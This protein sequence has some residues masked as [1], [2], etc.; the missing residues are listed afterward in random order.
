[1]H[2]THKTILAQFALELATVAD[3]SQEEKSIV[4]AWKRAGGR[5]EGTSTFWAWNSARGIPAL[6][7]TIDSRESYVLSIDDAEYGYADFRGVYVLEDDEGDTW[8]AYWKEDWKLADDI[9]VITKSR[10]ELESIWESFLEEQRDVNDLEELLGA[11]RAAHIELTADLPTFGGDPPDDTHGVW[12]WDVSSLLVGD[13]M[14]DLEI[15]TRDEWADGLDLVATPE[16]VLPLP[17][18]PWHL[19]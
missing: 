16:P 1:M 8:T 18:T 6:D 14:T 2:K 9:D 17:G 7:T 3:G 5:A 15:I 4:D 10:T 12:S 19:R 11:I 13:R